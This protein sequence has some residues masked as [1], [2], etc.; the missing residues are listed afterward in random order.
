[1]LFWGW[2]GKSINRQVSPG[3]AVVLS[4]RYF[5]LMFVFTAAFRYRYLLATATEQGWATRPVTEPEALAMLD[6]QELRPSMWQR[7]SI[8]L[9]PLVIA[10][11]LAISA[12]NG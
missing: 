5:H 3:Q 8:W 6:G 4:Y 7:Y 9:V 10:L 11:I 12:V 2:G 1:M